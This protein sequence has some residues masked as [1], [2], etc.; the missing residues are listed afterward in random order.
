MPR[1]LNTRP[2]YNMR[3]YMNMWIAP[4]V[5]DVCACISIIL[6]GSVSK[7]IALGVSLCSTT[8]FCCIIPRD[9]SLHC[10]QCL[11]VRSV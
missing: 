7:S 9:E 5:N 1:S 10:C 3:I 11:L 2:Y 6:V 8:C 4:E